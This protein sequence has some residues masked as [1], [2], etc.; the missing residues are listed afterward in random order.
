ML[1]RQA[2][3][4]TRKI[5]LSSAT[6]AETVKNWLDGK[7]VESKAQKWIEL[8]NPVRKC[9]PLRVLLLLL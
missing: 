6:S 2:F 1:S 9:Y 3:V 4:V 7:A 8:T 5:S